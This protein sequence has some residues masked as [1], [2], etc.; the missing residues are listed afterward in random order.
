MINRIRKRRPMDD[1]YHDM[2]LYELLCH[3]IKIDAH[4]IEITV[5][6]H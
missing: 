2:E 1:G 6:F 3:T 4:I 5:T